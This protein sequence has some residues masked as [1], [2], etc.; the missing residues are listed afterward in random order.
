[1][2]I[3]EEC[4][5]AT[6]AWAKPVVSHQQPACFP[7]RGTPSVT[8]RQPIS[9]AAFKS[10]RCKSLHQRRLSRRSVPPVETAVSSV[11]YVFQNCP[12]QSSPWVYECDKYSPPAA[13]PSLPPLKKKKCSTRRLIPLDVMWLNRSGELQKSNSQERRQRPGGTGSGAAVWTAAQLRRWVQRLVALRLRSGAR[14]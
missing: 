3:F 12:S 2:T 4:R 13:S 10:P 5:V 6:Q 11:I 8:R 14:S 1:M 7:K 9:G